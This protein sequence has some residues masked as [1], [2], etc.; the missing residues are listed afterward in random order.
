MGETEGSRSPPGSPRAPPE[1]PSRN[2]AVAAS[3]GGERSTQMKQRRHVEIAT[4]LLAT[5]QGDRDPSRG[6]HEE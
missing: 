2:R 5:Q 4:P 1:K 3:P 6:R